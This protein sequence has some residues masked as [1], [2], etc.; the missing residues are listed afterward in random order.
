MSSPNAS[1]V[2]VRNSARELCWENRLLY[3]I[4]IQL[5]SVLSFSC[6]TDL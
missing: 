6:M 2:W 3:Q 4:F 1:Y 5:E